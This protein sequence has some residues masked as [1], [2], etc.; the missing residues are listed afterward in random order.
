[1]DVA[2]KLEI[3]ADAAK[4]DVACT[5]SG[6]DRSAKAGKLGNTVAAGCCHS[7]T[8]DGRC[9]CLLK[10]LM[11]NA[12]IYDC[13]YCVNRCTNDTRRVAFK[14]RELADLTIAFYR[15]NYIEG[16]F[17]SSG[18]IK[19]PDFT[20]ELM[21]QT[22]RILREEYE[23]RGYIHVKAIPGTSPELLDRLGHLADR[24]SVNMELPTRK[25]LEYLA[26]AKSRNDVLTPMRRI[27]SHIAEDK[28][29][30]ALMRK[31]TSYLTQVHAPRKKRAYVP[32]GQST[33]M[34]I[35]ATPETDCHILNLSA[36][37]Y[38]NLQMK[39]VFFSAY[40]P[41]NHDAR[42]PES[43]EVQLNR[44]HRLYQ[45]DWLLRFYRFDVSEIIDEEHPFLD[46]MVD[47]KANWALNHLEFFPV[48]VNKAPLDHLMRV[49]GIGVR[50]AKLIAQ[51]RRGH[52]LGESELRKLGIAYKRAR[53]F[54]VCQ[55]KQNTGPA[56]PTREYLRAQLAQPIDGGRHGRRSSKP[57][58]GQMSLAQLDSSFIV[59]TT[60][61]AEEA[62]ARARLR[63]DTHSLLDSL[64]TAPSLN[65]NTVDSGTRILS[66]PHERKSSILRQMKSS[67][68]TPLPDSL[69]RE[70]W[71]A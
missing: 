55:G 15:R 35:G 1:M 12:C 62:Q 46:P 47:P 29:T 68:S 16:L 20:S 3:L 56:D 67:S 50:G 34:I 19:S 54:I 39:R 7:F 45:A 48:D 36:S 5:S 8:P 25:S 4:Y 17:L 33:Q 32:A 40:L 21:E 65:G 10:V 60:P 41:V 52:A 28:D 42:L 6:I 9:I 44:E 66:S 24:M 58:E 30:R 37:L 26:P 27:Q 57:I 2:E 18:V 31:H 61:T 11:T 23:F 38:K 43:S 53:F 22:L 64:D 49:P 13:A 63:S 71:S 59:P 70:L 51:A 14:P 69:G